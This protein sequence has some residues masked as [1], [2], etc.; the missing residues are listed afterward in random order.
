MNTM[1]NKFFED[2]VDEAISV[3]LSHAGVIEAS[4]IETDRT[5]RD[6]CASNYCGGYG[7]CWMCPPDIG[8]IDV[9]MEEIKSY[10]YALVY[11]YIGALEDSFDFEGMIEAK[12][13]HFA[14]SRKL[15]EAWKNK[16]VKRQLHL[17][18]GGCGGCERC[19][20][21][22]G[23]PCR[24]P[25]IAMPALEGYGVNVSRLAAASGMKYINEENTVT[26]FGAVLFDL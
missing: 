21:R 16:D 4:A 17:G 2:L 7:G 5:F 12:R 26:Y 14:L 25:D 13:K 10:S 9:L 19:A 24:H 11:Q 18:V 23:Q 8:D 20:K 6:I 15:R 3:G 22:D 1:V